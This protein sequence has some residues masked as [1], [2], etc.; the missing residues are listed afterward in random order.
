LSRFKG[1]RLALAA[2]PARLV[3]LAISDV[4]GD[5]PEAIGSGPTV[6]DPTTIGEARAILRNYGL[7][8]PE[9]GW[10]ETPT[11][12]AGEYRLVA[13][14]S[15]ALAAAAAEARALGYDPLVVERVGEAREA[16]RDHAALASRLPP[17][18]ALIS[19]GELT[20]TVRGEGMGGPNQE[21][22]LAA[23]L[24]LAGRPGISG[25]AADTDGIDGYGYAAGAFL[26]S[27]ADL[28]GAEAALEDNDSGTWLARRGDL[29]VTGPTGTNVNDLRILLT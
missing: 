5:A 13:R 19:G 23:A 6:A 22:A 24:A 25:L 28:A 26:E 7:D 14:Q 9:A 17:G 27:G 11:S 1:G 12:V 21:Y 29:F 4:V 2:A 16:G 18:S 8:G 10:S 15:E 20:V 3:T